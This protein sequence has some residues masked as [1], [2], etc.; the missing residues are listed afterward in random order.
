MNEM[1]F[2]IPDIYLAGISDA[3]QFDFKPFSQIHCKQPIFAFRINSRDISASG[4]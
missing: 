1:L 3:T 2:S 4:F